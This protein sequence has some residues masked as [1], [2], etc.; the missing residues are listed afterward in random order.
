MGTA[1]AYAMDKFGFEVVGMDTNLAAANN[2]PE[3]NKNFFPVNNVEDIFKNIISNNP[4]PDVVISSLP[5]HQTKKVGKWCIDNEVRYCDLGGRVDVSKSIN[6]YARERAKLPIFTDLGLAPGWVNILAEEGY[7][8]IH[9]KVDSV[10]MMVGGLPAIP[11]NPPLNYTVTWSIDGLINE[12]RD[13]CLILENEEVKTV[14]GMD[15]LQDIEFKFLEG[16]PLEAFYTSGGASHTIEAMRSRGVKNCSYKTIRYKGHRDVVD[17]LIRRA[18]LSDDCLSQ[19]FENGCIIHDPFMNGDVVLIKAVVKGG[20]V[21]WKKEIIV[22]YD[23]DFSAMQKAT[24][25]S[26]SS[27]AKLMA[28]GYFDARREQFRG[29]W[30]TLPIVLDYSS[31]PYD[32][33]DKNLKEL[34]V[35]S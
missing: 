11:S 8:R 6:D 34:G 9:H 21:T 12:Y 31:V 20:D 30:R 17:F 15:G 1:I 33:F 4:R 26:I 35:T 22:G 19:F 23:N 18:K 25:F 5:Y 28:E 29:Y 27:V 32:Q 2:M 13:D 10:E 14:K 24:A 3:G 7:R 16:E